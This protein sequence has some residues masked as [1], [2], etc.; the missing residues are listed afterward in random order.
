MTKYWFLSDLH[1]SHFNIIKYCD[2]PFKDASE[3]NEI[4]INNHNSVVSPGDEVYFL[5]DFCFDKNPE[6]HLLRLNGNWA[7]IMGNHD[8]ALHQYFGTEFCKRLNDKRL[9]NYGKFAEIKINGRDITLCHYSMRIW[10]RSHRGAWSL[11]G[12]SH[13]KLADDK[14]S[15]SMDV[16]VDT[17]NFF[18]YSFEQVEA[19]M[20]TK[21]FVPID[22]HGAT[23]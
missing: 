2:R 4:M 18:P 16:G 19:R 14:N 10:N 12:H 3:M 11:Y 9:L 7:F 23:E 6:K 5:G 22:H 21:T 17:N 8:K 13:G 20:K 15:L 1:L